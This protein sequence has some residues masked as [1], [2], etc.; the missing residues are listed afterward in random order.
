MWLLGHQPLG[1]KEGKDEYD[2]GGGDF[3]ALLSALQAGADVIRV[4]LFGHINEAG[5]SDVLSRDY[6]PLF[7]SITAPGWPRPCD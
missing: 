2:V 6:L 4:G 5:L 3:T 7:P 1:T